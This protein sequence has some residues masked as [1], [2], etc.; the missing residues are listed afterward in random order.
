MKIFQKAGAYIVWAVLAAGIMCVYFAPNVTVVQL[1]RPLR[2]LPF[3]IGGWSGRDKTASDYL[4]GTLGADDILLREYDGAGADKAELYMSYFTF[5]QNK[6][7]PHAPQLCWVGSGWALKD[8]GEE[9]LRLDCEKCPVAVFRKV[10]AEKGG[11]QILLLYMY[12]INSR[13]TT[14]LLK[15]RLINAFDSIVRRKNSA[16]TLQLSSRTD[17]RDLAASEAGL[18]ELL[19]KI[20]TAAEKELLP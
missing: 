12:K 13:Y 8:L 1:V 19:A 15:F 7:A 10:L 3:E 17:G 5:T 16:F 9:A 11:E 18:K 6:K 4:A 20:L 2:D 14:D